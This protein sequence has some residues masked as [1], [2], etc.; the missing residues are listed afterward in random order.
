MLSQ[1]A[2]DTRVRAVA[3]RAAFSRRETSREEYIRVR[4]T[5]SGL[6]LYSN[7]SSGALFSTC[8]SDG[9]VRQ[10]SGTAIEEGDTVEYLPF[11]A[12]L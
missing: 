2:A 3:G 4:S 10:P 7:Q 11:Q 8:W 1:G 6:E 5:G 12:F 9:L